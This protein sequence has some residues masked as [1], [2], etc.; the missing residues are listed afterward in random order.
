[1][2]P[3]HGGYIVRQNENLRREL[4]PCSVDDT[5]SGAKVDRPAVRSASR[6]PM[7]DG[8]PGHQVHYGADNGEPPVPVAT[9][10][11]G[12][13]PAEIGKGSKDRNH[14]GSCDAASL[15]PV[16][17]RPDSLFRSQPLPVV[18]LRFPAQEPTAC[19]GESGSDARM[20][21]SRA[22]EI[23]QRRLA[24]CRDHAS[25]NGAAFRGPKPPLSG[26]AFLTRVREP[27]HAGGATGSRT[28]RIPLGPGGTVCADGAG[29]VGSHRSFTFCCAPEKP[30]REA[31]RLRMASSSA[32]TP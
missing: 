9:D 6:S 17:E 2:L 32:A 14:V 26:A 7:P 25:R 19:P 12:V 24:G 18:R 15:Q 31:S 21:G 30:G 28:A 5:G 4:L 20:I 29:S 23:C 8:G 1:M 11:A 16:Q 3:D 27:T 13:V 22:G 10:Q